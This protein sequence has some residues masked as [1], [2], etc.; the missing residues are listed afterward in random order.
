MVIISDFN[1]IDILIMNS[2]TGMP[3]I[4]FS[5]P[6]CQ[7]FYCQYRN[8]SISFLNAKST[9]SDFVVHDGDGT[10]VVLRS[11]SKKL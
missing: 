11:I 1:I 7:Y 2:I 9:A 10:K 4:F 6:L 5:S 8:D 3:Y